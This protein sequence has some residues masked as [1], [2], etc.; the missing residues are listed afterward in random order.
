MPKLTNNKEMI[1]PPLLI[2]RS[3]HQQQGLMMGW[4]HYLSPSI[5]K[6][7]NNNKMIRVDG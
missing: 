3:R 2:I 4:M 7:N 6:H 5:S 1:P